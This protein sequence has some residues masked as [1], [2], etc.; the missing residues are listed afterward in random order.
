MP[1]FL[2]FFIYGVAKTL[3]KA[4]GMATIAFFGRMPSR[5]DDRVALV[6]LLALTWLTVVAAVA[7][8]AVGEFIIP[9][10]PEDEGTVRLIAAAIAVV[11]PFVN[12]WV[13]ST[14]HNHDGTSRAHTARE[15]VRGWWY[16]PVI[17]LTMAAVILVVPLLKAGHLVRRYEVERL[18]VMI[19]ADR[20]DALVAHVC[21]I[22]HARGI[23][24][25]PHPP[26]RILR[27]LFS[28]MAYVLGA[29]FRRRVARDLVTIR[30]SD[31]DDEF[32]EVAVHASDLTV[33][34]RRKQV[35]RV[36]AVLA[37]GLDPREVYVTWDDASQALE[38]RL[39]EQ[40]QRLEDGEPVDLDEVTEIGEELARVELDHEE[41]NGLRRH[42]FRLERDAARAALDRAHAGRTGRS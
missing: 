24:A 34:G 28:V 40:W 17:G 3:S 30:G 38:D 11:I 23:E 18:M 27:K 36:Y 13:V 9:F 1:A 26:A 31:A 39:R 8:P 20:Q 15:V 21:D 41:W 10:A 7:V 2:R 25:E 19:P 22:L 16:T 42:L 29:I 35:C 14:L 37:E 12:G 4:F 33:V 5:D 6:G 32:F